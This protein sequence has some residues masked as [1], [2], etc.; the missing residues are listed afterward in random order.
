MKSWTASPLLA[1][2][3]LFVFTAAPST[4]QA[5]R[6]GY[7]NPP[8]AAAR[9]VSGPADLQPNPRAQATPDTHTL[10]GGE[11]LSVGSL[12]QSRTIFNPSFYVSETGQ[13]GI[14]ASGLTS[15]TLLGGTLDV[16]RTWGNSHLVTTYTGG[17]TIYGGGT[18]IQPGTGYGNS[19][20]HD[21]AIAEEITWDRWRLRLRDD[22]LVS[23]GASFGG[24]GMGGP[25]L[26]GQF[27][28][29]NSSLSE[30]G[31]TFVPGQTIYTGQANRLRNIALAGA[32]YAFSRR[33]VMT[34]TGSY[35]VL[36]FL[37]PGFINSQNVTGQVG[38]D[39]KLDPRNSVA[40]IGG[41]GR[42]D[43]R[44][45]P[46]V[47]DNYL[48]HFAYGRKITGRLAFQIAAGP[49]LI[50]MRNTGVGNVQQWILGVNSA[51]SY[52][53]RRSG[54]AFTY[55]HGFSAGSG[56]FL[57]G[58]AHVVGA[59]M[60]HRFT[61]F[62]TAN[63]NTGYA[64]NSSLEGSGGTPY[65]IQSW[66]G[67]ANLGHPLGRH[68]D[69]AFNYGVQRQSGIAACPQLSCGGSNLQQNFGVI[70]RWHLRDE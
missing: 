19:S 25:G 10:S 47:T 65:G 53:R 55:S 58:I 52:E 69:V 20:F 16:D 11:L 68:M 35:G 36:H 67:G 7:A 48:T 32:E 43:Y 13:S 51:L 64:W 37:D 56:V 6:D 26:L 1:V 3:L 63:L 70:L 41:F 60:H 17:A 21:F 29:A 9:G 57:G 54:Y 39:Y 22:L 5:Q 2:L 38:F 42:T 8:A 31:S 46:F 33:A 18:T 12:E 61:R 49:T 59:N 30:I 15:L 50:R 45:S 28:S 14:A 27:A 4:A 40:L 34:F 23:P 62:W 44:G 24:S 66:Y